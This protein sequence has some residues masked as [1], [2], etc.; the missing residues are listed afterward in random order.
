MTRQLYRH[1]EN[2]QKLFICRYLEMIAK[3]AAE[4]KSKEEA[5]L[6]FQKLLPKIIKADAHGQLRFPICEIENYRLNAEEQIIANVFIEEGFGT[7]IVY[8][9]IPGTWWTDSEETEH[10][11]YT[12]ILYVTWN[13]GDI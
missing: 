5:K 13:K 3:K 4:L 6:H 11:E 2:P 7:T 1:N 10:C 12:Y 9:D 8:K